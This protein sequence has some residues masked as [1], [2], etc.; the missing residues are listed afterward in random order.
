[1]TVFH[2]IDQWEAAIRFRR[3]YERLPHPL[4]CSPEARAARAEYED[5]RDLLEWRG[6]TVS[7]AL[8]H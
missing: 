4:N 1:M 3:A 8:G 2:T 5:A 7:Q 6:V